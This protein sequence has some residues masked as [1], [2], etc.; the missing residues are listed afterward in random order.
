MLNRPDSE[1]EPGGDTVQM[2]ETKAALQALGVRVDTSFELS[3]DPRGYD[4]VHIFNLQRAAETYAQS[5][6]CRRHGIPVALSTIIWKRPSW[7][8]D[9]QVNPRWRKLRSVLPQ[10]LVAPLCWMWN[11]W[12]LH[13]GRTWSLQRSAV[14]VADVLLPNS[15]AEGRFIER[16]FRTPVT[17]RVRV[18]PNAVNAEEFL[19]APTDVGGILPHLR[20]QAFVLEVARIE[21]LK[22][23]LAL[24]RALH[25][26]DVPI[27]FVGNDGRGSDWYGRQC[28]DLAARRGNVLFLGHLPHEQLA[29]VYSAA[30]VHV[31][32]S[33]LET[34]GLV[35]LEAALMRCNVVTTDQGPTDEYFGSQAWYCSPFDEQS[36]RRAVLAALSAL[37]PEPLRERVLT[38]FTWQKAAAKTLEAYEWALGHRRGE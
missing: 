19:G 27:V 9:I 26:V 18:I 8:L 11:R 33:F 12:S 30:K 35:S 38:E 7:R 37:F 15:Q 28:R 25:D 31:L 2:F 6:A 23:Q 1:S 4:I 14:G 10:Y 20:G 22:N 36:I 24:L 3:P 5:L 34:T 29:P 32:P 16:F 13:H 21:P 17:D